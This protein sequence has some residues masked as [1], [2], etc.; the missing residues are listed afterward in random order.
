MPK[1]FHTYIEE[2]E[3]PKDI[4]DK[5]TFKEYMFCNYCLKR[6]ELWRNKYG[7]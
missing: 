4:I 5:G 2:P 6:I 1:D 3:I 7:Y